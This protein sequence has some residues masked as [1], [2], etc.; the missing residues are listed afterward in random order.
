MGVMQG[1]LMGAM[2]LEIGT[3]DSGMKTTLVLPIGYLQETRE[4]LVSHQGTH[5]SSPGLATEAGR[6]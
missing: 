1:P 2:A 3:R 5:P 6:T 4:K